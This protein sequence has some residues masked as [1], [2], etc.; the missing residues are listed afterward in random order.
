MAED[1]LNGQLL[2]G[3]PDEFAQEMIKLINDK[4]FSDVQ[5]VIGEER[6]SIHAH[7]CILAAR[8]E[9]F[10]AMF[11]TPTTPDD[12]A[13]LILSDIKPVV[14]MAVLEFIYT[15]SC[16][17][18]SDLVI[19]VLASAIE[20]GLDGLRKVCVRFM[21]ENMTVGTVCEYVQA[22]LTYDQVT[23]REE[24]LQLIEQHTEEVFKTQGFTEIS[25][26]ALIYILKSNKLMMDEIDI[27]K[28]VTEWGTVNAVVTGLSLGEILKNVII[29]IRYPLLDKD[30]LSSIAA[31]NKI[32][33][34]IPVT[35][36]AA[37]WKFHAL[38]KVDDPAD[39]QTTPRRGTVP[40]PS[41]RALGLTS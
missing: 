40:R 34:Y 8:C 41:L 39:P 31:E 2:L 16:N 20:Y 17:L 30:A 23:L 13:P 1:Y 37:A 10:R 9:V 15:N 36:I 38:Q 33:Q 27:L 11:S 6:Q 7:K 26:E 29:H 22:A 35:L 3:D 21:R 12:N 18:S 19:E 32:K 5:F 28:K 24:C 25:D 4:E 14:F